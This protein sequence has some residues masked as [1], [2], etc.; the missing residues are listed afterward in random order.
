MDI[1]AMSVQHHMQKGTWWRVDI[2]SVAREDY[3]LRTVIYCSSRHGRI[4]RLYKD[5][6]AI[7]VANTHAGTHLPL[8][9]AMLTATEIAGTAFIKVS[10]VVV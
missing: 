9:V 10:R 7:P 4:C 5:F 3:V 2:I 1:V 6:I 8:S